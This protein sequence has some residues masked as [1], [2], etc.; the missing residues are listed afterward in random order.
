MLRMTTQAAPGWFAD[1]ST[2]GARLALV[3]QRMGWGNVAEAA[4]ACGF[5]AGS[6]RNWE[7]DGRIPRDQVS[8]ARRISIRTGC[9]YDWLLDGRRVG[10]LR[11]DSNHEPAGYGY[12]SLKVAA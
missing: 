4:E 5:A 9:D 3:R 11:M 8:I 6:W 7:R 12:R 2:F 10:L 1:D